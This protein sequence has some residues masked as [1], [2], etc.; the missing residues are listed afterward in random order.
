MDGA[1][2]L[3]DTL[4]TRGRRALRAAER[5]ILEGASLPFN[6]AMSLELQLFNSVMRTEDAVEDPRAFAEKRAPNY[7]GR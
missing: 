3:A 1:R 7:Q 5:A 2:A 4:L 6:E